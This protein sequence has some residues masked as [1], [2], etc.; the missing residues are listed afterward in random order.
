VKQAEQSG[1]LIRK[2]LIKKLV[3]FGFE[4]IFLFHLLQLQMALGFQGS[5]F[6]FLLVTH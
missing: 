3:T 5:I 2:G 4:A 1:M 6:V